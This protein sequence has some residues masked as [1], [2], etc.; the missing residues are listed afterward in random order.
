MSSLIQHYPEAAEVVMDRC[1][2]Q[3]STSITY[4]FHY[5]DPGPEDCSGPQKDR[6]FGLADMVQFKRKDLLIHPLAKKLLNLKWKKFGIFIFMINFLLY[7][8][9]LN[10]LTIFMIKERGRFTVPGGFNVTKATKHKVQSSSNQIVPILVA[11]FAAAHILKEIIQ[12]FTLGIRY[13]KDATNLLEWCLYVSAF[14]FMSFFILDFDWLQNQPKVR[15]QHVV[16]I[17][18]L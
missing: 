8:V 9:F 13:F 2:Q 3:S 18:D 4:N 15:L 1:V 16:V 10:C 5:L 12:I 6:Y 7:L 17:S 14:L 11:G